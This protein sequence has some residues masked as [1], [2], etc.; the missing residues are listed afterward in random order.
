APSPPSPAFP[1]RSPDEQR[2]RDPP[3]RARYGARP[4]EPRLPRAGAWAGRRRARYGRAGRPPPAPRHSTARAAAG[5]S[6]ART[7]LPR[8]RVHSTPARRTRSGRRAPSLPVTSAVN[9]LQL[10]EERRPL[11]A[12]LDEA[13][14]AVHLESLFDRLG[15]SGLRK[16][17]KLETSGQ[18]VDL[19]AAC[20]LDAIHPDEGLAHRFAD[21]HQAVVAQVQDPLLAEIVHDARSL[22]A[23]DRRSLEVV[24]R[25]P[26]QERQGLLRHWQETLLLRGDRGPEAAVRVDDPVHVGRGHV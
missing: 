19:N 23:V 25:D 14:G 4:A 11:L 17:L 22:A 20:R 13:T 6:G 3:R 8:R 9:A 18:G 12:G 15:L 16:R 1:C 21:R 24:I 26:A 7:R 5:R 2:P 10:T